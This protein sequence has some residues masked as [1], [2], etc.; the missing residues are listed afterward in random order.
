MKS[1]LT[2]E[3]K[4]NIV[5]GPGEV[6]INYNEDTGVGTPVGATRGGG[7]FNL[8]RT[9]RQITVDGQRGP[10]KGSQIMDNVAPTLTVRMLEITKSNLLAAIAGAVEDADGNIVGGDVADASYLDNVTIVGE[11]ANGN[12][13]IFIL[14]NAL[15]SSINAFTLPDKG[16][17]VSEVVFSGHFDP[18]DPDSEPWKII[19][20][21]A[22]S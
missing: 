5:F 14:Y 18:T 4:E 6:L 22:G 15:P 10:W 19:P 8:N 16:E 12:D 7:E 20:V 11:D 9:L 3:T 21:P 1:G 2:T 17:I 13:F